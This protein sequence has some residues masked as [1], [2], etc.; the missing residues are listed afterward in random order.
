MNSKSALGHYFVFHRLRHR[1]ENKLLLAIGIQSSGER[2]F[3][4]CLRSLSG[5][6]V[7]EESEEKEK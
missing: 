3:S 5:A 6:E 1:V 4:V 2:I 7:K